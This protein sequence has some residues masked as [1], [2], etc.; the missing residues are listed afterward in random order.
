MS[1]IRLGYGGAANHWQWNMFACI[2]IRH[3]TEN[4]SARSQDQAMRLV[5]QRYRAFRAMLVN[6]RGRTTNKRDDDGG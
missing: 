3:A 5:E 2:G 1:D 4:G 6:S